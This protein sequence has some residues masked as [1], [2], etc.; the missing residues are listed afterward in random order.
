MSYGYSCYWYEDWTK[1]DW[2]EQL[3][4]EEPDEEIEIEDGAYCD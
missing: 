3:D 1:W 4:R 2:Q